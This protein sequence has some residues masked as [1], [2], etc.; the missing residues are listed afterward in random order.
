MPRILA[1][2]T[3][4][5]YTD[6]VIVETGERRILRTAKT[7]TTPA[8]LRSCIRHCLRQLDASGTQNL[9]LVCLSTTLATNALVEGRGCKEGLILIGGKPDGRLP[10]ER[11]QIL[12]GKPDIMGRLRQPLDPQQVDEA[13]EAL[14]GEAEAV[15]IS[16]YASVRNPQ[17][18]IIVK[19]RVQELLGVPVACAHELTESLG[20][21]DRTVTV[22]LNARLIPLLCALIDAVQ[23][24]LAACGIEAPL[25]IVRGDGTLMTADSARDRPIET[26]L[27]GPAASI[28]GG[29]FLSGEQDALI[30]DMGGT[31]TDL[32]SVTNGRM[33]LRPDGASV[34]GWFTRI[35]AAEVYTVGL[36]GDSRICLR[37]NKSWTVGPQR[38]IPFCVAAHDAPALTQELRGLAQSAERPFL[39]FWHRENEAYLLIREPQTPSP[40]QRRVLDALR[41]APHTLFCLR[42]QLQIGHLSSLLD[43]W[44]DEGVLARIALTP[45]DIAHA[46]GGYAEWDAEASRLIV[47]MLA[48]QLGLD[49]QACL[50]TLCA[51][52]RRQ[53][54]SACL[55]SSLYFD[56]QMFNRRDSAS[57]RYFIDRLLLD[58][59]S[60]LLGVKGSLKKPLVAVGA[61]AAFWTKGLGETLH[62]K[63]IVPGYAEVANA[64]GAAVSPLLE[65]ADLLIRPDP[66]THRYIVFAEACRS[67]F[68]TLDEA[69]A[70]AREAGHKQTAAR[71]SGSSLG[72]SVRIEDVRTPT[73]LDPSDDFVERHV[74]VTAIARS[75]A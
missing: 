46:C 48:A 63:V 66:V 5:T 73:P 33:K 42:E 67:A 69:T 27:S 49:T 3:G 44:V 65:Q 36:G 4:G 34:G 52:V 19:K 7:R 75:P 62:T 37:S 41:D 56:G 32:A 71:L 74:F 72:I 12:R 35:R 1:I 38:A 53:L 54:T 30:L 55:E 58:D 16:G 13:I 29:L 70:F 43:A 64:V 51:L 8:D 61:P 21:Y 59:D 2:D 18:E 68:D 23:D 40:E 45:T 31:T 17:H 39:H 47:H 10:T 50:D 11:C 28:A 14:R 6:G 57:A 20:F 22:S 15:A 26:I 24:T 9:A 25:M 60:P